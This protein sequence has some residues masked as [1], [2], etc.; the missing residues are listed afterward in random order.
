MYKAISFQERM[1]SP[2]Y[3]VNPTLLKFSDNKSYIEEKYLDESTG[4][5]L[6]RTII[7]NIDPSAHLDNFKVSDFCLENLISIGKVG[8][9]MPMQY[10]PDVATNI[11]NIEQTLSQ[12]D[13]TLNN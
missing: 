7:S 4:R 13:N 10:Q 2:N 12:I 3:R 8:D 1:E 5:I 6:K 11:T 9:L